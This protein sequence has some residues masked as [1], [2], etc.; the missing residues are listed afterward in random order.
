MTIEE[1]K[2]L[3]ESGSI[4][5]EQ[6]DSMAKAMGLEVEEPEQEEPEQEEP[7]TDKLD[8]DAIE[9]MMQS[10]I[11]RYMSAERKKNAELQKKNADLE[12]KLER[13]QK[14][15]MTDEELQQIELSNKEKDIE[16]R[17]KA[18][19]EQMNRLYAQ[20]V[21]KKEGLDDG[22]EDSLAI[23][24]FVLGEDET[25]IDER[26]K[27]FKTLFNKAVEKAVNAEVE[28]RFKDAARAPKKGSTLNNGV[29]P[30]SKK[31]FS[32]TEQMRIESENPELA[33]Q[34]EAAAKANLGAAQ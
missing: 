14:A 31:Q 22:S 34:L 30:Y 29:N 20:K 5:Q 19:K 26:V 18:L 4:T 2:K 16:E 6:F 3:L 1:L 25:E 11:D 24:D 13:L 15:N 17:E 23:V 7:K 27:S 32:L 12:K 9:K 8:S 28:K 33:K 21:L 10:K